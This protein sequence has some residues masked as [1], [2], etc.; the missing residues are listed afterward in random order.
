LAVAAA[1]SSFATLNV[2]V[3]VPKSLHLAC[4]RSSV[5]IAFVNVP[6]SLGFSAVRSLLC[7]YC[8]EHAMLFNGIL[9]KQFDKF[10]GR[11]AAS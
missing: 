9:S 3:W 11:L 1:A 6:A 2:S 7:E 5:K 10:G 8:F 4:G